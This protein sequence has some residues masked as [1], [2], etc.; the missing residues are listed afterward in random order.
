MS[1][2]RAYL[3]LNEIETYYLYIIFSLSLNLHLKM[4]FL[5]SIK[6]G[7]PEKLQKIIKI[8]MLKLIINDNW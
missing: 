1:N 3:L 5:V 4:P 2:K 6:L 8:I 7:P